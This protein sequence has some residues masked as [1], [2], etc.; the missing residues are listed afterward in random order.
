MAKR[1]NF[2]IPDFPRDRPTVDQVKPLVK[3]IYDGQC[4]SGHGSVGGCLH[5]Q[6]DDGNISNDFWIESEWER[7]CPLCKQ[8]AALMIQMT[9]TQRRKA[10]SFL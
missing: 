7:W 4:E 1:P 5:V 10:R 9:M 8:V 2:K 6:L 3:A